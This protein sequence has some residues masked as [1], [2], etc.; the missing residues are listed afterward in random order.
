MSCSRA[1]WSYECAELRYILA[2]TLPGGAAQYAIR[3][4]EPSWLGGYTLSKKMQGAGSSVNSKQ[5]D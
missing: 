2:F 5:P 4:K 1:R 3:K